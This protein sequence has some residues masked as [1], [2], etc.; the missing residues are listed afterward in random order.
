M[1]H[2][3][4]AKGL[5][6]LSEAEKKK[7]T[8]LM[9]DIHHVGSVWTEE[10]MSIV[11]HF[12]VHL[13]KVEIKNWSIRAS[14]DSRPEETLELLYEKAAT[15]YRGLGK[16]GDVL[17]TDIAGWNQAKNKP[18]DLKEMKQDYFPNFPKKT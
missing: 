16:T 18:W 8:N 7:L 4:G 6:S 12:L 11:S 1:V 13:E 3:A 2:K 17:P 10:R 14:G 5:P 15:C 9:V